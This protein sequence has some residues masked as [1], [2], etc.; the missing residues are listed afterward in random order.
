ML[1]KQRLVIASHNRGKLKEF[2]VLLA[3]YFSDIISAADLGLP[4]PEETGK[5]FVDNA[6]LKARAAAKAS[7]YIALAD[8]SGLCV[9]AL[10][11]APG[12]YSGRYAEGPQ[13]RDFG[14]AIK[15][16]NDE[17]GNSTDRSAYFIC[18][19][20]LVES[21]GI[22]KTFEGRLSGTI[23]A[24]PRGTGGHGYDPCFIPDGETRAC[25]EMRETEKNVISHRARAVQQL[26]KWLQQE[27]E[28]SPPLAGGVRGGV[29]NV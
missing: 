20:A 16:L 26:I 29:R 10:N 28:C 24:S 22:E 6:L 9:N 21:G 19:L 2:S 25:A 4:E 17:I 27:Q 7:G 11:G 23:A 8:D 14:L 15:R 3:P 1:L 13:G 5:T 12:V 18:V